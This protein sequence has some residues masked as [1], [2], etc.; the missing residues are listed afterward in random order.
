MTIAYYT[1]AGS[2]TSAVKR[3]E[4]STSGFKVSVVCPLGHSLIYFELVW[5]SYYIINRITEE[6]YRISEMKLDYTEAMQYMGHFR[7]VNIKIIVFS[8]YF[9]G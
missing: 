6:V 1:T 4:Q 9:F 7:K 5:E 8:K 3:F 2:D